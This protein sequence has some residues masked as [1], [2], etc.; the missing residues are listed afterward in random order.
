MCLLFISHLAFLWFRACVFLRFSTMCFLLVFRRE[1]SFDFA[2][3][4][5][6][7]FPLVLAF[8][9]TPPVSIC[10]SPLC[11]V[12]IFTI[13][14]LIWLPRCVFVWSPRA[15]SV[16]RRYVS[17]MFPTSFHLLFSHIFSCDLCHVSFFD[18]LHICWCS[19]RRV[20]FCIL[21]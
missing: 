2:R 21:P 13:D 14:I 3:C 4:V 1:F 7:E 10:F 12:L 5:C 19:I 9:S 6:L 18:S 11:F 8:D 15:F 20:F 17:F 16:D